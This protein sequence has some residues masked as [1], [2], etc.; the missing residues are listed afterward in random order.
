MQNIFV[1][2]LS[3]K[4]S[5]QMLREA[6]EPFG[7]VLTVRLVRDRDSD[8]VRGFAF[9]EMESEASAKQAIEALDGKLI[10]DRVVRVN[11]ARP[12]DLKGQNLNTRSHRKHRY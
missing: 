5:E 11:E 10:D 4:T 1:G 2:N 8:A 7:K 9:V 6:F 12:K 3:A